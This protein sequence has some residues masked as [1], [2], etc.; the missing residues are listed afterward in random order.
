MSARAAKTCTQCRRDA[1][2]GRATCGRPECVEANRKARQR[3]W[4][5]SKKARSALEEAPMSDHEADAVPAAQNDVQAPPAVPVDLL[6]A[7][8][9]IPASIPAGWRLEAS[10]SGV[11][12]SWPVW[13]E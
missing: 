3:D 5:I 13:S 7:V 1:K 10:T 12:L 2:Y 6:A 11:T 4:F 8:A 9:A